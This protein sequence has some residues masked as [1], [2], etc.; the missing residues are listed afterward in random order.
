M[1]VQNLF[2]PVDCVPE[3]QRCETRRRGENEEEERSPSDF[4]A[5]SPGPPA[6]SALQA[7]EGGAARGRERERPG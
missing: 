5:R 4:T 3:N 6:V 1:T 2:P 7:A